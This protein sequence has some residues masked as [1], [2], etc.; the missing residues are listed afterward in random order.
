[1]K[2][3]LLGLLIVALLLAACGGDD[4]KEPTEVSKVEA[5]KAP[6]ATAV[7]EEPKNSWSA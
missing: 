1:M 3:L 5:T 6:A 4:D 7:P 2:K